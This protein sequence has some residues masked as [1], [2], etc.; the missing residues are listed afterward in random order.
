FIAAMPWPGR[1]NSAAKLAMGKRIFCQ[2]FS[3]GTGN[4]SRLGSCPASVRYRSRGLGGVY[5]KIPYCSMSAALVGAGRTGAVDV[6]AGEAA[7]VGAAAGFVARGRPL[8]GFVGAAGAADTGAGD[9]LSC[10]LR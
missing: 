3:L 1:P 10:V 7:R 9:G 2:V 4:W 8:R 5:G 6:R